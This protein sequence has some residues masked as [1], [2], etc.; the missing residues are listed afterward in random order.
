LAASA[1]P[2][3]SPP[4]RRTLTEYALPL[5]DETH[6]LVKV[7]GAPLVVVS[8]LSNSHL[9]KLWLDPQ[10]E[11]VTGVQGFPLGP[12][13]AWLH[14]LAVSKRYPGKIWATHQ[15]GNRLL[16]V[17][18]GADR[19][20]TSPKILRTIDI[21]GGGKGP[22]YAG[23]YGHMLWASLKGSNQVLAIDYTH[24]QRYHLYQAEPQ[25]IF[26]ARHP[27]TAEFYASQDASLARLPRTWVVRYSV[28]GSRRCP[29]GSY[30][31]EARV[32]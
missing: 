8:Q 25:P 20:D 13:D 22:H 15:A 10:S 9:V 14:G 4:C 21:P 18:P 19:L 5:A 11:Q 12:S 31:R 16:L 23:E 27:A 28:L 7:P 24:P 30:Y 2:A 26:V 3:V 1:L 32:G 29:S 17:D 6:E